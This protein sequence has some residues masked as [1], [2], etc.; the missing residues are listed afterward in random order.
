MAHLYGCSIETETE[1]RLHS[2]VMRF[3]LPG[4]QKSDVTVRIYKDH[5]KHMLYILIQAEKPNTN[6]NPSSSTLLCSSRKQWY[7]L[8]THL[9]SMTE[10]DISKIGRTFV[11]GVLTLD[12]P[13]PSSS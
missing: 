1:I 5:D 6:G 3:L 8:P 10:A 2:Y 13:L 9:Y 4:F 7:I 11:D 12:F